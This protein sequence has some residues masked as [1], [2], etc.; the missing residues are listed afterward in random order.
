MSKAPLLPYTGFNN[1][2]IMGD[3]IIGLVL[4]PI[5]WFGTKALLKIYKEKLQE[6]VQKLKIVQLMNATDISGKLINI[7]KKR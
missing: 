1:T 6:K 2:V 5:I 3:F 7:G 4:S